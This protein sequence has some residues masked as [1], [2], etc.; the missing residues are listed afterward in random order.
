MTSDLKLI[1]NDVEGNRK[2]F[3]A[4]KAK[5]EKVLADFDIRIEH[6]GS[7]AVPGTVGKGI[8]DMLLICK[9]EEDQLKIKEVLIAAGYRQGELNKVPDGRLFFCNTAA[10]THAGDVHL[11]LVIKGS[12]NLE[13][14]AFRNYLLDHPEEVE[15]YNQEKI[16][17]AKESNN[18]R[19]V[20]GK[21]KAPFI[22]AMM[23]KIS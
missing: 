5:L 17:L 14:L 6:V 3:Q 21:Q 11:H 10:Q 13:S 20:Y 18:T 8:I 22:Q 7:T 19:N 4:E 9:S 1:P 23:K 16:R 2:I 12:N 15:K